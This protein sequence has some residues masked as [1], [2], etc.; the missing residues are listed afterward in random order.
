MISFISDYSNGVHPKILEEMLSSNDLKTVGYG[1]DEICQRAKEKIRKLIKKPEA[2]IFFLCGGT[3]TNL[4]AIDSLLKPYQGV[5]CPLNG[6]INV[7]EAGAIENCGHK[8]ISLPSFEGKLR[9]DDLAKYLKDFYEDESYIHMVIPGMVYI[10]Y[11][12]EYGTLYSKE[13]LQSIYAICRKYQLPFYIDGARLGY[14][15]V[16]GEN[17]ISDIADSCDCFYIGATKVGGLFGEALVF[18]QN[19]TPDYMVNIIKKHGGLLAKGRML[20]IQFDALFENDLYFDISRHADRMADILSEAFK[21]KGYKLIYEN[22]TNQTFVLMGKEQLEKLKQ[23]VQFTVWE[24]YDEDNYI[25]RFVTD[26]S[27][28]ESQVNELIELL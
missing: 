25:V 9:A 7:H 23:K 2:D 26:W 14:G 8:V 15:V 6:H 22:P 13:E 19:N 10:S 20:G 18:C 12:T 21:N 4:I 24:K 16:R 3:Q 11:P 1:E 28:T 17:S 5:I 27:T